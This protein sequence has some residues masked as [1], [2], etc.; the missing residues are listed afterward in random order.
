[1]IYEKWDTRFDIQKLREHLEKH[2]LPLESVQ[3]SS[4]FGG[5][6]VLSSNGSYK[7]GWLMGH[8]VIASEMSK[9]ALNENLKN[10]G[11]LE[12]ENYKHPTEICHGYLKEV[13]DFLLS[14]G[15]NPRR[16][17]MIRLTKG[18]RSSWHRDGPDN[19]YFVRLHVPIITN[20]GCIFETE[21]GSV[22]LPADGASYFLKVNRMHRVSNSGDADR[23]HLVMDVWDTGGVTQH[24]RFDGDINDR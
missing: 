4:S 20:E 14:S 1:M 24:H 18:L 12:I 8:K 6:S 19:R 17:R 2:I 3:Q 13:A 16:L 9:E 15:L 23:F 7:D 21:E 5:W 10:E 11:F 22:H